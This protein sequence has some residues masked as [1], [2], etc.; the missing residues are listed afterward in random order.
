MF[1]IFCGW[2]L[3]RHITIAKTHGNSHLRCVLFIFHHV[4][5][6]KII[7]IAIFYLAHPSLTFKERNQSDILARVLFPP[8]SAT[9]ASKSAP[10]DTEKQRHRCWAPFHH[11]RNSASFISSRDVSSSDIP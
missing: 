8:S 7:K 4:C 1:Y 2:F 10:T 5:H 9:L 3:E 11:K 6:K